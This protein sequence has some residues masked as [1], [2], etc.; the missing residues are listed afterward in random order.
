MGQEGQAANVA[1]R[2]FT[3]CLTLTPGCQA[4][5]TAPVGAKVP[6][7]QYDYDPEHEHRN[8]EGLTAER[9]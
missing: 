8:R 1:L 4:Q 9:L 5:K 6:P 2:N 3:D 7:L